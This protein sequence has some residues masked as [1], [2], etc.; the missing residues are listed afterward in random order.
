MVSWEIPDVPL[1]IPDAER[2]ASERG[3]PDHEVG[4]DGDPD[5]AHDEGQGPVLGPGLVL[6]VGDGDP[7]RDHEGEGDEPHHCSDQAV[8]RPG[9]H[10][11]YVLLLRLLIGP[12]LLLQVLEGLLG[13]VVLTV[14]QLE[15]E[16]LQPNTRGL[17]GGGCNCETVRV[18]TAK[19]QAV[20][21][22]SGWSGW[23][24]LANFQQPRQLV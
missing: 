4:E 5:D 23:S 8:A 20:P 2:L 6:R 11:V 1:A 7:H 19:F 22:W 3:P 24:G 21:G 15:L 10:V 13:L 18:I 14:L 16:A 9:P 12:L 17:G